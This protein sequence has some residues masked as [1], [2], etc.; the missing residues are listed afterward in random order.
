VL[1][2]LSWIRISVYRYVLLVEPYS[3]PGAVDIRAIVVHSG[4]IAWYRNS[5]YVV[6]TDKGLGCLNDLTRIWKVETGD[7]IGRKAGGGFSAAN[8]VYLLPQNRCNSISY[9][10]SHGNS[11]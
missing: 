5:L 10:S 1:G 2:S 3:N 11:C 6:D 7:R 8:Y 9:L 4:G